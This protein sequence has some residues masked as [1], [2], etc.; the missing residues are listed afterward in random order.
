M[1]GH[2]R[3]LAFWRGCLKG[4][5]DDAP[6]GREG[7]TSSPFPVLGIGAARG[8]LAWPTLPQPTHR[9]LSSLSTPFTELLSEQHLPL[10]SI[11]GISFNKARVEFSE[12]NAG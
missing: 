11:K 8:Q 5:G 9:T 6:R 2:Q 1:G 7:G 3:G 10:P 4:D 12:V